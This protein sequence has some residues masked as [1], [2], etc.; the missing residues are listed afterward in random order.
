MEK[1]LVTIITP[2]FNDGDYIMENVMS[3]QA[4][5]YPNI[6]QII[7]DDGSNERTRK[8][9]DAI[10][11]P[12]VRIIHKQNEGV[13]VARNVAIKEAHGEY[14]LP[15][16]G[17]DKI[18]PTYVAS[19]IDIFESDANV[20]IVTTQICQMF[21]E[22]NLQI[23]Q[24]DFTMGKLLARNLFFISTFFKRSDAIKIGGFDT[25][26]NK[27]LEDWEFWI[28]I[29]KLGGSV[30]VV[31]GAN[32]FW[33]IKKVSRNKSFGATETSELRYL[34]WKKH[35]ELFAENFVD[36]ME[37]YEC[38]NLKYIVETSL[39]KRILRK[40]TTILQSFLTKK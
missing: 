2:C 1:P 5:T 13:C 8:V 38:L 9:L 37:T 24:T 12:N 17:D 40:I 33:R 21:G 26:F 29:M 11:F 10:N 6:E 30:G 35:R 22:A 39:Y 28:N 36:P 23:V 20:R 15:V 34:M 14:I 27:G 18:S 25:T 4:Q 31:P 7:I 16:D 3:V 19:A 32:G